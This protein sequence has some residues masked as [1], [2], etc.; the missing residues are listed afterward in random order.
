MKTIDVS[1]IIVN[2]RTIGL[3]VDAIDS[4]LENTKGITYEIILVDNNSKDN[5]Q[6]IIKDKYSTFVKYIPL[7]KNLGFGKANNEGVKVATGRNILFLNPDTILLNNAIKILSDILDTNTEIGA[8][9]GN[10]YDKNKL[11]TSS[12]GRTYPSIFD[13]FKKPLRCIYG[14]NRIYNYSNNVINV[15]YI[16]GADLMIKAEVIKKLGYAFSPEIFMYY[17]EIE[18]CFRISKIGYRISSV[19]YAKI[20]HLESQSI[21]NIENKAR[22]HYDSEI[23]YYNLTHSKKYNLIV[24]HL[25]IHLKRLE[26]LFS[27]RNRIKNKMLSLKIKYHKENVKQ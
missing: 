6:Q 26:Q 20:I 4:I 15:A 10:L 25:Y 18:L 8:C 27:R 5:S 3:V 24:K 17:E 12:F 7:N 9:G 11:P 14:K 2:Y 21:R 1:I 16:I 13:F 23:T 19:P 22:W